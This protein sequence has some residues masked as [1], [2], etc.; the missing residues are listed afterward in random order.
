MA[1]LKDIKMLG[2]SVQEAVVEGIVAVDILQAEYRGEQFLK[3]E[4]N[5]TGTALSF[6]RWELVEAPGEYTNTWTIRYF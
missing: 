5:P 1:Q 4:F 3:G 2:A 6:E